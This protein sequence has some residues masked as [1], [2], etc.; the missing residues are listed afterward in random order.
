[1]LT[2]RVKPPDQAQC[3]SFAP[4]QPRRVPSSMT[5]ATY[6]RVSV[7]AQSTWKKPVASRLLACAR[8]TVPHSPRPGARSAPAAES[9]K[10][11]LVKP[12]VGRASTISPRSRRCGIV[13]PSS[14]GQVIVDGGSVDDVAALRA[15]SGR[16][17]RTGQ[18]RPIRT[19]ERSL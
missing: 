17:D 6:S 13:S 16:S 14:H 8:G 2:R 7:T 15:T 19:S 10:D 5:N 9:P 18:T 12:P 11:G 1:M 3:V 4:V